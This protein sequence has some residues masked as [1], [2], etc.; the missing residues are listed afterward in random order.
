MPRTFMT[1]FIVPVCL[2]AISAASVFG[3]ATIAF[4]NDG[5]TA[6]TN[7]LT[8]QRAE[9]GLFQAALYYLPYRGPETN[10]PPALNMARIGD[11]VTLDPAGYYVGPNITLP[12]LVPS[13]QLGPHWRWLQVRVWETAYGSTYEKAVAAPPRNGRTALR[14]T[15]NIPLLD[16]RELTSAINQIPALLSSS[17]TGI[18]LGI[19]EA[20]ELH[21]T[22]AGANAVISWTGSNATLK[23]QAASTPAGG[24]GWN[25]ISN[26]ISV[27]GDQRSVTVNAG[28]PAHF[29]RLVQP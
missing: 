11:P 18:T 1:T 24:A 20:P 8:G 5:A 22:R 26:A 23:L 9:A 16:V 4:F 2:C 29:Y 6:V 7:A 3:Q 13:P 27:A 12:P 21:I 28:D 17:I 25:I 10:S 19:A 15:S 14:G